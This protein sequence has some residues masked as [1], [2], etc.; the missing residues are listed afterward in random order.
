MNECIRSYG[1][2]VLAMAR[3]FLG[4]DAD[5]EEAVQDVFA[6]VWAT[7]HRHDPEKGSEKTMIAMIARRRLIDR[8]RRS[9]RGPQMEALPAAEDV[10]AAAS[11]DR[12]ETLDEVA[13][14]QEAL[15]R[16]KPEQVRVL[17]LS[18]FH[19][20]SHRKISEELG[21]P[22]GTIKT[23]IRRGLIQIR[24]M[25]QARDVAREGGVS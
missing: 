16:L 9:G 19:G 2:L 4:N 5:A 10:A 14:V 17:K 24:E 12:V 8:L 3:R 20:W 18:I 11:A 1:G 22:L 6:D 21:V 23:N 7:A 15:S 25:L 13:K